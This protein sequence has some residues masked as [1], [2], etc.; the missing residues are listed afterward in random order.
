MKFISWNVNGIRAILAKGFEKIFRETDADIFCLQETKIQMQEENKS[1]QKCTEQLSL[2]QD[3][4]NKSEKENICNLEILKNYYCYWNSA[5][6]KG[7]SGTAIFSK[8][9]PI[10][11]KYGIGIEEHD[12][13]GRIITLEFDEFYMITIYTPNSKRTLERLEYRVTWEDAVRDYLERL[14]KLKPIIL[15]GDL[16]VAHNP[17]DLNNPNKHIGHAGFTNVERQKFN[18][19]LN[20]GFIDTFRYK[21]P[22]KAQ[23]YT[24]WSYLQGEREANIGWRLDYFLI[25]DNLKEK[26]Q[27]A[28]IY[29]D[30]LGSDHCPIGIEI[31]I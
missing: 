2:F 4:S 1:N 8:I 26:L 16:N 22:H 21:Y 17:I 5:Q 3:T 29:S 7:Y 14:N 13:E 19:L 30:I 25:S 10:N 6:K 20:A 23:K 28:M 15:C 18:Q 12:T 9:K 31:D 24:W 27:D 11:V